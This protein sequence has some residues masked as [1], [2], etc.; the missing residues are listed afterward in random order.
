MQNNNTFNFQR[1]CESLCKRGACCEPATMYVSICQSVRLSLRLS[2]I[3][4]V[5]KRLSVYIPSLHLQLVAQTVRKMKP[6]EDLNGI[7]VFRPLKLHT[8]SN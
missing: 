3:A 2:H 6:T 5:S 8:N 1:F 7:K 4:I